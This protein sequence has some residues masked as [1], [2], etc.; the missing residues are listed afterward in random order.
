MGRAKRRAPFLGSRAFF[1]FRRRIP[2]YISIFRKTSSGILSIFR[3]TSSIIL[4]YAFRK[5][6][7]IFRK[8][9]SC[10]TEDVF[11]NT[12]PSSGIL[13]IFHRSEKRLP[14]GLWHLPEDVF[15]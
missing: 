15:L 1:Y 13:S 2:E 6:Y 9:S 5:V 14:E 8:T 7:G 12:S 4:K 11:Q 10:E 3:K